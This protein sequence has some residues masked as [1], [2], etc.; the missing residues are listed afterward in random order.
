VSGVAVVLLELPADAVDPQVL[1]AAL[2]LVSR[3]DESFAWFADTAALDRL[4]RRIAAHGAVPD[5]LRVA[6]LLGRDRAA[7]TLRQAATRFTGT[8]DPDAALILA[9]AIPDP[10]VRGLA[11]L[12]LARGV[13]DANLAQEVLAELEDPYLRALA[14]MAEGRASSPADAADRLVA[15]GLAASAVPDPNRRELAWLQL[16]GATSGAPPPALRSVWNV[17]LRDLAG[18]G[19]PRLLGELSAVAPILAGAAP[20]ALEGAVEQIAAIG[21]WYA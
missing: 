6:G 21:R 8:G 5:V 12:D 11:L 15:A 17:L 13:D 7:A 9:R 3:N 2:D 18:R 20:A 14:L 16:L 10:H 19:R 1:S 4:V